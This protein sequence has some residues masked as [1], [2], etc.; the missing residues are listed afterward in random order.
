[1][2]IKTAYRERNTFEFRCP[3][4]KDT[5]CTCRSTDFLCLRLS[6]TVQ[7]EIK[8]K[9]FPVLFPVVIIFSVFLSCLILPQAG[10]AESKKLQCSS[11]R[12]TMSSTCTVYPNAVT[13]IKKGKVKQGHII[14]CQFKRFTCIGKKCQDTVSGE[15]TAFSFS[16]KNYAEFCQL[17]CSNPA[18]TTKWK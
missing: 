10:H 16:M 12:D 18:C 2:I 7:K 17:L 6:V 4:T 9:Q 14:S 8:M 5:V 11:I 15:K 13:K 3:H 1:M